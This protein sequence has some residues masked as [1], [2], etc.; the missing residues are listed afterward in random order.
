VRG[1]TTVP[2]LSVILA[3]NKILRSNFWRESGET[4]REVRSETPLTN[5][6]S[7]SGNFDVRE[8]IRPVKGS[9]EIRILR[10]LLLAIRHLSNRFDSL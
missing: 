6:F 4:Y 7:R 2:P 5:H 8:A 10:A 1:L 9:S 3:L